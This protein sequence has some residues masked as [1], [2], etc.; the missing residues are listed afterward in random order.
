MC[1]AGKL[2]TVFCK[3]MYNTVKYYLSFSWWHLHFLPG[4]NLPTPEFP[5]DEYIK[6]PCY[7]L[8][9]QYMINSV[10]ELKFVNTVMYKEGLHKNNK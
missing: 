9:H 7:L 4:L 5:G 6:L 1:L 3:S 10:F 2:T 8:D